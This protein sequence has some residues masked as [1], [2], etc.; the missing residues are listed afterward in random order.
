MMRAFCTQHP[1]PPSQ[2]SYQSLDRNQSLTSQRQQQDVHNNHERWLPKVSGLMKVR[3]I[4]VELIMA[5][6]LG[7]KQVSVASSSVKGER[8]RPLSLVL[9]YIRTD[10]QSHC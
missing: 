4:L 2:C 1:A 7:V 3:D 10:A 9:R 5:M 6:S 8:A